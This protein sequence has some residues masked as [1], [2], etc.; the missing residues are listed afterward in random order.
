[1]PYGV[2][3]DFAVNSQVRHFEIA[4]WENDSTNPWLSND[5][6]DISVTWDAGECEIHPFFGSLFLLALSTFL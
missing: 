3:V 5:D 4:T 1:M 2:N 6:T